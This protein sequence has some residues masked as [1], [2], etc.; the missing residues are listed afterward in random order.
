LLWFPNP[1]QVFYEKNSS[2]VRSLFIGLTAPFLLLPRLM[3]WCL[4]VPL[5]VGMLSMVSMLC[6]VVFEGIRGN[7]N[8][9]DITLQE[10]NATMQDCD[11]DESE[12]GDDTR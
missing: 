8:G 11:E 7:A 4:L 6:K 5:T 3:W 12:A 10:F 9:R 2:Y 1:H